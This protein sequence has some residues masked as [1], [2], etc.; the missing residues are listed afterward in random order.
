MLHKV[1]RFSYNLLTAV[2]VLLK[3]NHTAVWLHEVGSR[4]CSTQHFQQ[5][6]NPS[7]CLAALLLYYCLSTV[8]SSQQMH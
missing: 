3:S 7:S 8:A 4:S 6:V 2:V 5:H 1:E